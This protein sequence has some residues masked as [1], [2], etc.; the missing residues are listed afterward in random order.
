MITFHKIAAMAAML[1][2]AAIFSFFRQPCLP[3]AGNRFRKH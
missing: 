1:M 3:S 2:L